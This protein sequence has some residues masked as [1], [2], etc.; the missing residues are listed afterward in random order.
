VGI[1]W[2]EEVVV[3]SHSRFG[4]F[5]LVFYGQPAQLNKRHAR[6]FVWLVRSVLH[7]M[8][9]ACRVELPTYC[10]HSTLLYAGSKVWPRARSLISSLQV[11]QC[12]WQT[13]VHV[14]RTDVSLRCRRFQLSFGDLSGPRPHHSPSR[15][16]SRHTRGVP[17]RCDV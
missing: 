2:G 11:A 3:E 13:C 7:D 8:Y 12:A 16:N 1:E 4:R 15:V 5:S 10:T 9:E 17:T 14:A 6:C